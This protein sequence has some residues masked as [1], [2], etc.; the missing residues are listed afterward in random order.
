VES[1][2]CIEKST[3]AIRQGSWAWSSSD[4]RE[5]EREIKRALSRKQAKPKGTEKN[6]AF[7]FLYTKQAYM[8]TAYKNS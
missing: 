4:M 1:K 7:I 2:K 6:R 3:R 5:R 8:P